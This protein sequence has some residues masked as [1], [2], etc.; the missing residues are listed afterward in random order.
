MKKVIINLCPTGSVTNKQMTQYVP[1]NPDEIIHDI[2]SCCQLG[3]SIAHIHACSQDGKPTYKKEVYSEIIAGI[4]SHR[5]DLIIVVTTSGRLFSEFEQRSEVLELKNDLKPDMASLT[6]G[7]LNF[8]KYASTNS[9][10]LII[11]LLEKMRLNDIKPELEIFDVGMINYANYLI[12]K[13]LL[14]PPYYFNILLGNIATAQAKIHHLSVILSEIPENSIW[15]VAGI[16]TCQKN[17]NLLGLLTGDGVRVGLEDNIWFDDN[18]DI[19]ATN[20]SLVE[21]VVKMAEIMGRQIATP[22]E[23][24][25]RLNLK[26]HVIAPV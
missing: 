24:R 22:D 2:L 16:G 3:V 4:R 6:L 26:R 5:P 12:S 11:K 14:E 9:P 18:K 13:G 20:F 25:E 15:S 7:S 1:Q 8:A 19:L 21:R 10:E 23:V 17:M